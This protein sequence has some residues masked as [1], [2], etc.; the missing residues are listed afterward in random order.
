MMMIEMVGMM[1]IMI[2]MAMMIMGV[3]DFEEN[4]TYSSQSQDF[5]SELSDITSQ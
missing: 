2:I 1:I 3:L 5:T 4:Y